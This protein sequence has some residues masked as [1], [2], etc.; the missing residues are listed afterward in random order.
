MACSLDCIQAERTVRH[1]GS[2]W[3]GNLLGDFKPDFLG[4]WVCACLSICPYP[5]AI[6]EPI[7]LFRLNMI[8]RYEE[9]EWSST[10]A[11]R[12][13]G[14]SVKVGWWFSGAC[15]IFLTVMPCLL[16]LQS[17]ACSHSPPPCPIVSSRGSLGHTPLFLPHNK[18][19]LCCTRQSDQKKLQRFG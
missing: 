8:Q 10:Q 11:V 16:H 7:S 17:T 5:I 6:L 2:S 3:C 15:L 4:K 14:L 13:G 12:W 9:Q 18:S 19:F 1:L